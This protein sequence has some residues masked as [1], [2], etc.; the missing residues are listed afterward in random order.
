M[1]P[2]RLLPDPD[3]I[4]MLT[5]LCSTLENVH[6]SLTFPF[7]PSGIIGGVRLND[8]FLSNFTIYSLEMKMD[9]FNRYV[10]SYSQ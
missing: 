7:L 1:S 10:H 3:G 2:S 9:F 8:V 4:Y 6:A 5:F